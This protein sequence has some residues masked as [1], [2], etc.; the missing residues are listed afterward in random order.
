MGNDDN[1][2]NNI[3]VHSNMRNILRLSTQLQ[4][5]LNYHQYYYQ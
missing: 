3:T 4:I 5:M 2:H 1:K